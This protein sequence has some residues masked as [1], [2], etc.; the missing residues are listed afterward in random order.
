MGIGEGEGKG[1]WLFRKLNN[2]IRTVAVSRMPPVD[3]VIAF[4]KNLPQVMTIL[5]H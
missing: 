4:F 5:T 2:G 1:M 3:H